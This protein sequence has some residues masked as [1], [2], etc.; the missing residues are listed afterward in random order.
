MGVPNG[1]RLG[2]VVSAIILAIVPVGL[3]FVGEYMDKP[4]WIADHPTVLK[5]ALPLLVIVLLIF[6]A[7]APATAGD[8]D[9]ATKETKRWWSKSVRRNARLV[10]CLACGKKRRGLL[11]AGLTGTWE[12]TRCGRT[13]TV[14]IDAQDRTIVLTP[15]HGRLRMV[16]R[17]RF[18]GTSVLH[19]ERITEARPKRDVMDLGETVFA[20]AFPDDA[21]RNEFRAAFLRSFVLTRWRRIMLVGWSPAG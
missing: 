15:G 21:I 13:S 19:T 9:V 12:C 4:R 6:T 1:A 14:A 20:R 16:Q 3:G 2:A 11:R 18:W 8:A 7:M 10:Q 17:N 5:V